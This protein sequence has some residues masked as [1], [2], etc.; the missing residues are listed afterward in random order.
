VADEVTSQALIAFYA[1][2]VCKTVTKH[3]YKQAFCLLPPLQKTLALRGSA[4]KGGSGYFI[5][6]S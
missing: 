4:V 2:V 1:L 5:E 3:L 6:N